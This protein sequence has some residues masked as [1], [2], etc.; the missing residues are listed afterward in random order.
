MDAGYSFPRALFFAAP[1]ALKSIEMVC[2]YKPPRIEVRNILEATEKI[3]QVQDHFDWVVIDDLSFLAEQTF[4]YLEHDRKLSGFRL[5][6]ALRDAAL[7]FRDKSRYCGVNVI[8]NAWEQ[9]PGMKNGSAAR[10]GPRLSGRLPEQIPA[11][12]DVVLRAVS[13]P[14]RQPWPVSYRCT[15]ADP[16]WVMKDRYDIASRCSPAPMNMAELLRAA[17]VN[18]PRMEEWGNQEEQVEKIA[19]NLTGD[20]T[21]DIE[22][23]NIAYG[24]LVNELKEPVSRAK[25][26]LR[27]AMDRAA[28]R[29]N[30]AHAESSFINPSTSHALL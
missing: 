21:E 10:G 1:G 3:D 17:G 8:S 7:Q 11:M 26:T 9:P 20:L 18:C 16:S 22:I 30:L 2:G 24:Q 23:L 14:G 5:W 6:G 28:I 27:D 29:A 4:Q 25:W 15:P 19:S 13:E 12:C